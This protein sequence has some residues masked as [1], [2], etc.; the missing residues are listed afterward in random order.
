MLTLHRSEHLDGLPVMRDEGLQ[1]AG[2][3]AEVDGRPASRLE[4]AVHEEERRAGHPSRAPILIRTQQWIRSSDRF[5]PMVATTNDS[6]K[7]A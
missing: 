1:D 3:R 5:Y 7:D 4:E 2:P 6:R